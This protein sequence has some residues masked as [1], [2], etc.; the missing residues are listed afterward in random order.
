MTPEL[1]CK[2]KS[3]RTLPN[4][5]YL[6]LKEFPSTFAVI[7]CDYGGMDV[8]VAMILEETDH[9]KLTSWKYQAATARMTSTST[10]HDTAISPQPGHPKQPFRQLLP[11]MDKDR[12]LAKCYHDLQI[13]MCTI[14]CFC[15]C[16]FPHHSPFFS[17]PPVLFYCMNGFNQISSLWLQHFS[18]SQL[19]GSWWL[20]RRHC[21]LHQEK[22]SGV[23][24]NRDH[25][26]HGREI[27]KKPN[28]CN[29]VSHTSHHLK[30]P[31]LNRVYPGLIIVQVPREQDI[32]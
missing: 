21:D 28:H 13:Q 12:T 10:H 17:P 3:Q 4:P 2:Q 25:I 18:F 1:L 24:D 22:C 26:L 5:T 11:Y 31:K 30:Y 14:M 9:R 6:N 19:F 23:L 15:S 7:R 8:H 32:L 20:S 16:S 27:L 29:N